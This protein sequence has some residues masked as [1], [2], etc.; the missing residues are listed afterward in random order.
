MNLDLGNFKKFLFYLVVFSIPFNIKKFLF[1][2]Q[3][4]FP[5]SISYNA[6]F[7]YLSDL[8]ILLLFFLCF[9]DLK[10]IFYF[11]K[12]F[13]FF[14]IGTF[15]SIYNASNLFAF[16]NSFSHLILFVFFGSVVAFFLYKKEVKLSSIFGIFGASAL[17][18]SIWGILQFRNQSSLGAKFLGESV[19]SVNT[20]GV[21]R[22]FTDSG[23]FLR[24]YGTMPHAN[25]LAAFL[26]LGFLAFLYLFFKK[27]NILF[28]IFVFILM[29]GIFLTFSR[30]GIFVLFL[31]ILVV[32]IYGFLNKALVKKTTHFLL[33]LTISV[34]AL[35]FTFGNLLTARFYLSKSEP[36]FFYRVN[37]SLIGISLIKEFPLLG[38]GLGNQIYKALEL[39][40]YQKQNLFNSWEWQP[41]H[42]VYLM[43]LAETGLIGFS[44]FVIFISSVFI[45]PLTIIAKNIF[46]SDNLVDIFFPFT[47]G[48]LFL[49]LGFVDHFFWDLESGLLMFF[50]VLGIIKGET[51]K[52]KTLYASQNN[53]L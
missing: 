48:I 18:Q 16:L 10:E 37:Y 39:G 2:F 44:L 6:L 17:L 24:V 27:E 19:L 4:R 32:I 25:I 38:V 50:L 33:F 1:L 8:L 7:L 34:L 3:S 30:S 53:S 12:T 43:V 52:V 9:K 36:S 51:E 11:S 21:A 28:L 47:A 46:K 23:N 40:L 13:Y 41:I 15:L 31:G 45:K 14:L 42:N 49:L 26:V 22:V 29:A 20:S 35:Y 5:V